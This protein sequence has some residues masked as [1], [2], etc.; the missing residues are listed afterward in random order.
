MAQYHPV[1]AAGA[2]QQKPTTWSADSRVYA[3]YS[4]K[5]LSKPKEHF[6]TYK[7]L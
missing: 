2:E 1:P 4:E 5:L 6:K 7:G 3:F